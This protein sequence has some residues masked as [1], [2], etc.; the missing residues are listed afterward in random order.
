MS[1]PFYDVTCTGC[2]YTG[3]YCYSVW[4]EFEGGRAAPCQ[5]ALTQGWCYGCERVLTICA[6]QSEASI[7][8]RIAEISGWINEELAKRSQR[9]LLFFRVKVDEALIQRWYKSIEEMKSCLAYWKRNQYP[10]RC[11][12]CG[13]STVTRIELPFDFGS[14][15]INITHSCGGEIMAAM[16]G[17]VNYGRLPKVVYDIQ[18]NIRHDER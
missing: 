16:S 7:Q 6:P 17:R 13:S 18:G 5:P 1:L 2:S 9:K 14:V 11:L 4:Y 10:D 8:E 3:R 15:L 12:T